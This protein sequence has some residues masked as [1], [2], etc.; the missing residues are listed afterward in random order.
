MRPALDKLFA[1]YG[2]ALSADDLPA[3][4]S[5]F[6]PPVVV[7]ADDGTT[8]MV[9]RAQ[10]K[11][12]FTGMAERYRARGAFIGTP[13]IRSVEQLTH[14]LWLADVRWDSFDESGEPAPV[15][16]ETYR[17]LVRVADPDEPLIVAAIVTH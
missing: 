13:T 8:L 4:V 5:C 1:R 3:I 6:D 12:H 11:E 7:I 15:D 10:L 14:A 17:Y 2:T 16:V 9:D